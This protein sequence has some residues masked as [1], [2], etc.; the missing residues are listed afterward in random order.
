M[1]DGICA[2]CR[3]A[4]TA[5]AGRETWDAL[6]DSV[7]LIE[8]NAVQHA[9]KMLDAGDGLEL[10]RNVEALKASKDAL[11][12]WRIEGTLREF[13]RFAPVNVWFEW[14]LHVVDHELDK[15]EEAGAEN[16]RGQSGKPSGGKSSG[17]KTKKSTAEKKN[18]AIAE[19]VQSCAEDGVQPTRA[20]VLERLQGN[21]FK[22]PSVSTF[23]SWTRNKE[24]SKWCEWRCVNENGLYLLRNTKTGG[25]MTPAI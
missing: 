19:A 5:V 10:S 7:K 17:G 8:A 23:E 15:M 22:K 16:P 6:P 2:A 11:S 3:E 13:P 20:N 14:P 9:Y 1:Q 18:D 25:G 24:E 12:A 21:G 4:V